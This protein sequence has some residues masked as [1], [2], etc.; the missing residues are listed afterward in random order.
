MI[1]TI[2]GL[3]LLLAKAFGFLAGMSWWVPALLIAAPLLIVLFI[4]I[5]GGAAAIALS[6]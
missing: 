6:K 1:F 4:L 2:P 5:V 3:I